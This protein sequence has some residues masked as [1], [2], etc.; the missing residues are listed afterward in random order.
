[1][2]RHLWCV[3][4]MVLRMPEGWLLE[5]YSQAGRQALARPSSFLKGRLAVDGR[6]VAAWRRQPSQVPA[7]L[8]GAAHRLLPMTSP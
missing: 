5:A 7:L 6:V 8:A 1:M 4:L 2:L 3:A